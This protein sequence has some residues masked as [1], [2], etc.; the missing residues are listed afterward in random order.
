[1]SY[2]NKDTILNNINRK[3]F[4]VFKYLVLIFAFLFV[5]IT[6]KQESVKAVD[7]ECDI[8]D[9]GANG[10]CSASYDSKKISVNV[11][12]V[13]NKGF[14]S[15]DIGYTAIKICAYSSI[16]DCEI[17]GGFSSSIKI[18]GYSFE[19]DRKTKTLTGEQ[20]SDEKICIPNLSGGGGGVGVLS[21]I[22]TTTPESCNGTVSSVE[23]AEISFS[24]GTIFSDSEY[25]GSQAQAHGFS[26][27]V[28]EWTKEGGSKKAYF[29]VD[30]PAY[31]F[32]VLTLDDITISGNSSTYAK[33]HCPEITVG[34]HYTSLKYAWSSSS[35]TPEDAKFKD[36]GNSSCYVPTS[37]GTYYFHVKAS[38]GYETIIKRKWFGFDNTAPKLHPTDGGYLGVTTPSY[39]D[40]YSAV[41]GYF[42]FQ[43]L[44]SFLSE[45]SF[46]F[47]PA[48]YSY[49][50]YVGSEGSKNCY[51]SYSSDTGIY[52]THKT[53]FKN[54]TSF[55]FE[56]AYQLYFYVKD[57]A[58]NFEIKSIG[59]TLY[60]DNTAP[61][62]GF[63]DEDRDWY[64]IDD[65]IV[66]K[67]MYV[68]DN[69]SGVRSNTIYYSLEKS[70]LTSIDPQG[71]KTLTVNSA[72]GL[73]SAIDLSDFEG[74]YL[75]YYV[76]DN[77]GNVNDGCSTN[78]L[79]IDNVAPVVEVSHSTGVAN[80]H[81]A[82]INV[83][84]GNFDKA[85]SKFC[86]VGS[87]DNC[88]KWIYFSDTRVNVNDTGDLFGIETTAFTDYDRKLN[89]QYQLKLCISDLAGNHVMVD[90]D[91]VEC[92]IVADLNFD[93][94]AITLDSS[95]INV[96]PS[97]G[98]WT[99]IFSNADKDLSNN[100]VYM[101][102]FGLLASIQ[103]GTD[104]T[105]LSGMNGKAA[106]STFKI[107]VGGVDVT[108][109]KRFDVS[110][111]VFAERLY[112]FLDWY[113]EP[114]ADYDGKNVVLTIY[115]SFIK[116]MA[117]NG[118]NS[119]YTIISGYSIDLNSEN[120]EI[121]SSGSEYLYSS[122]STVNLEFNFDDVKIINYEFVDPEIDFCVGEDYKYCEYVG[123][124]I[125][126][127]TLDENEMFITG[128]SGALSIDVSATNFGNLYID[129]ITNVSS[130]LD[131][132]GNQV[133]FASLLG[134]FVEDVYVNKEEIVITKVTTSTY[135]DDLLELEKQNVSFTGNGTYPTVYSNGK[136]NM[137]IEIEF[138][139]FVPDSSV[140]SFGALL[141]NSGIEFEYS[142]HKIDFIT[143]FNVTY[144]EIVTVTSPSL[145]N[146]NKGVYKVVYSLKFKGTNSRILDGENM[147]LLLSGG[148][149]E[150]NS[151]I[152][153]SNEFVFAKLN[154]KGNDSQNLLQESGTIYAFN[155]SLTL[156]MFEGFNYTEYVTAYYI[157]GSSVKSSDNYCD[158]ISTSGCNFDQSVGNNTVLTFDNFK[159]NTI[160]IKSNI[161]DIYGNNFIDGGANL[162]V[163]KDPVYIIVGLQAGVSVGHYLETVSEDTSFE[164]N[165]FV[166]SSTLATLKEENE[167]LKLDVSAGQMD[168]VCLKEITVEYGFFNGSNAKNVEP[169]SNSGSCHIINMSTVKYSDDKTTYEFKLE[170]NIAVPDKFKSIKINL[171]AYDS[172]KVN[173]VR[174]SDKN[175]YSNGLYNKTIELKYNLVD[176]N[177]T[178]P[179]KDIFNYRKSVTYAS[180]FTVGGYS[181][182]ITKTSTSD[183]SGDNVV[184]V[185]T[186]YV[187]LTDI[188]FIL[189]SKIGNLSL[190]GMITKVVTI[191]GER[192][193]S[194]SINLI[195]T[196]SVY[197]PISGEGYTVA[198]Y[199]CSKKVGS[200]YE[201]EATIDKPISA[202]YTGTVK[203]KEYKEGKENADE[204]S[205]SA[206][207]VNSQSVAKIGN[208]K[209]T[210]KVG[211]KSAP[212]ITEVTGP[213]N[214]SNDVC[215]TSGGVISAILTGSSFCYRVDVTDTWGVEQYVTVDASVFSSS[216]L[217]TIKYTTNK[218]HSDGVTLV[219]TYTSNASDKEVTS[220]SLQIV[221]MI[222]TSE[223]GVIK[224][225]FGNKAIA[226][227][228]YDSLVT[229][230]PTVL[231]YD[232][233]EVA[234]P[235]RTVNTN[236]YYKQLSFDVSFNRIVKE[237][238]GSV[239]NSSGEVITD[240]SCSLNNTEGK[241][242]CV[243]KGNH[244]SENY[245]FVSDSITDEY[246]FSVENIEVL[247]ISRNENRIVDNTAP[248]LNYI[249][250]GNK[251]YNKDSEFEIS[252]SSSTDL[253]LNESGTLSTDVID[254]YVD[255]KNKC[256]VLSVTVSKEALASS[257]KIIVKNCQGTG[258]LKYN[259]DANKLE[260]YA[261]NVNIVING[262]TTISIDNGAFGFSSSSSI[263]SDVSYI[264]TTGTNVS[265][266]ITITMNKSVSECK[267]DLIS[268]K[269]N[270]SA[271]LGSCSFDGDKIT[272]SVIATDGSNNGD[273]KLDIKQ[274][275]IKDISGNEMD[276]T[277][278]DTTVNVL[279]GDYV[280]DLSVSVT[281][282]VDNLSDDGYYYC[283][284]DS[285]VTITGTPNREIS[286]TEGA[287][288]SITLGVLGTK[289]SSLDDDEFEFVYTVNNENGNISYNS[290]DLSAFKDNAGNS[291]KVGT[292]DEELGKI[293]IVTGGLNKTQTIDVK[294]GQ[295]HNKEK[296]V[297][298]V[299]S[300]T[301]NTYKLKENISEE[302]L[303]C[304]EA[305]TEC[306]YNKIGEATVKVTVK[307]KAGNTGEILVT[308]SIKSEKIDIDIGNVSV[309][310]GSTNISVE[311]VEITIPSNLEAIGVSEDKVK[312]ALSSML[313]VDTS[314][315]IYVNGETVVID[316][317]DIPIK[318]IKGK[319]I[320]TKKVID[321]SALT[322]TVS[323]EYDGGVN[324]K[325]EKVE[326]SGSYFEYVNVTGGYYYSESVGE[327]KEYRLNLSVTNN[328]Y[329]LSSSVYDGNNGIITQ[330]EL[331]LESIITNISK[332][333]D[334][335]TNVLQTKLEDYTTKYGDKLTISWVSGK[336]ANGVC[337]SSAVCEEYVNLLG[338]S[339]SGTGAGNYSYSSTV[340]VTGKL[341]RD[342]TPLNVEYNKDKNIYIQSSAIGEDKKADVEI[343]IETI[344]GVKV[345][346]VS[347]VTYEWCYFTVKKQGDSR[348]DCDSN[349]SS[350]STIIVTTEADGVWYV[351]SRVSNPSGMQATESFVIRRNDNFVIEKIIPLNSS[352]EEATEAQTYNVGETINVTM[353]FSSIV[354]TSVSLSLGM[355]SDE[356]NS[357]TFACGDF[358]VEEGKT[359]VLCSYTVENNIGVKAI[360]L[361]PSSLIGALY[362]FKDVYGNVLVIGGSLPEISQEIS[363]DTRS[364]SL[365]DV[366]YSVDGKNSYNN[367]YYIKDEEVKLSVSLEFNKVVKT[368]IEKVTISGKTLMC[369]KDSNDGTIIVCSGY[370]TYT[371][372]GV[373][374]I[375]SFGEVGDVSSQTVSFDG[376]N[377][378]LL[379]SNYIS[380]ILP[381]KLENEV[382]VDV[383][384]LEV[385]FTPEKDIV[386]NK[387]DVVVSFNKHFINRVICDDD[388]NNDIGSCSEL[389]TISGGKT[390]TIAYASNKQILTIEY[391]A[392][393]KETLTF[394]LKNGAIQDYVGNSASGSF[395]VIFNNE[396]LD[397]DEENIDIS[398]SGINCIE[399]S[400]VTICGKDSE[401]E[402]VVPFTRKIVTVNNATISYIIGSEYSDSIGYSSID[403][404]GNV[405]FVVPI[406]AGNGYFGLT[407]ITYNVEDEL[408]VVEI[409]TEE[410]LSNE[411]SFEIDTIG[412][413]MEGREI[414]P[415]VTT[416]S[417]NSVL[418]FT[419]SVDNDT[420]Y[421]V[422]VNIVVL[423]SDNTVYTGA[424]VINVAI[425]DNELRIL[426][427]VDNTAKTGDK[428]KVRIHNSNLLDKV[429][430]EI[431]DSQYYYSSL[432]EVNN[433]VPTVSATLSGTNKYY[434]S[435]EIT[436]NVI[437]SG[438]SIVSG[439]NI[440]VINV[441]NNDRVCKT[442]ES[443]DESV[444]FNVS[445]DGLSDGSYK[446]YAESGFVESSSKIESV[447]YL[448]TSVL[449]YVGSKNADVS[450]GN[451]SGFNVVYSAESA[452]SYAYFDA[453]SHKVSFDL[454]A[455]NGDLIS[456]VCSK[457]KLHDGTS[458]VSSGE[459]YDC[460]NNGNRVTITNS[461]L[462]G[463]YYIVI[464]SEIV[465]N[466]YYL[467]SSSKTTENSYKIIAYTRPF[468]NVT[469]EQND[470]NEDVLGSD[471][472]YYVKDDS[473]LKFDIE[474]NRYIRSVNGKILSAKSFSYVYTVNINQLKEGT[475]TV[476]IEVSDQLGNEYTKTIYV[477]LDN[478][479]PEINEDDS[480]QYVYGVTSSN[481]TRTL[482]YI[483]S[484]DNLAVN[485][486]DSQTC[487]NA[488]CSYSDGI[489]TVEFT[490]KDSDLIIKLP[491]GLL[492]DGLNN[493]SQA[494][495]INI[496]VQDAVFVIE[497]VDYKYGD[498][499]YVKDNNVNFVL[500]SLKG[501]IVS[502]E[503]NTSGFTATKDGDAIK[504]NGT[505]NE[506]GKVTFV[507]GA[508]KVRLANNSNI[509]ESDETSFDYV[510]D[511]IDPSVDQIE[512]S[513][514]YAN[515][516]LITLVFRFTEEIRMTPKLSI[517]FGG[518]NIGN[519]E[520]NDGELSAD[521]KS[522]TYK[523][524]A[525]SLDGNV[526]V[527]L[528]EFIDLAGNVVNAE[529]DYTVTEVIIDNKNPK[530]SV[531]TDSIGFVK[532]G[533]IITVTVRAK[534][535]VKF[536]VNDIITLTNLSVYLSDLKYSLD[537][538]SYSGELV[539]DGFNDK[540][541]IQGKVKDSLDSFVITIKEGFVEDK[542]GNSNDLD[543]N[544]EQVNVLRIK[545][546]TVSTRGC[547]DN[548]CKENSL[549]SVEVE[550][551]HEVNVAIADGETYNVTTNNE[552]TLTLATSA[553]ESK[554]HKFSY[555]VTSGV[556]GEISS[557]TF[558]TGKVRDKDIVFNGKIVIDTE[559]VGEPTISSDRTIYG[560]N[561][562]I[563]FDVSF[564]YEEGLKLISGFGDNISVSIAGNKVLFTKDNSLTCDT[565][566]C[567]FSVY[568]NSGNVSGDVVINIGDVVTDRGLNTNVGKSYTVRVETER[569]K[570]NRVTVDGCKEAINGYVYC[571]KEDTI[572]ISVTFDNPLS[573]DKPTLQ[574]SFD[575]AASGNVT[576]SLDGDTI[577]Y[578]YIIS[579]YDSGL[580]SDVKLS[581]GNLIDNLGNKAKLELVAFTKNLVVDNK[582]YVVTLTPRENKVNGSVI[583]DYVCNKEYTTCEL[584][585]SD[586]RVSDG[587]VNVDVTDKT[588]TVSELDASGALTVSLNEGHTVKDY[589]GNVA[590]LKVNGKV[591]VDATKLSVVDVAVKGSGN[592]STSKCAVGG[593]ISV[594]LMFNKDIESYPSDL[595]MSATVGGVS[596]TFNLDKI[597]SKDDI[598][599]FT[600]EVL[601]GDEGSLALVS[602]SSIDIKDIL[603]NVLEDASLSGLN[604]KFNFSVDAEG[605]EEPT[606]NV[607]AIC[608]NS[609]CT[610]G[611]KVVFTFN[612]NE[613]ISAYALTINT[614]FG[615][616]VIDGVNLVVAK[617]RITV[618]IEINHSGDGALSVTSISGN[619][620]DEVNNSSSYDITVPSLSVS[621]D[622]TK[623]VVS[624]LELSKNSYGVS[625]TSEDI[626]LSVSESVTFDTNKLCLRNLTINKL[627][628]SS[629]KL[630]F[631]DSKIT[632]NFTKLSGTFEI[633]LQSGFVKDD[634]G[635]VNEEVVSERFSVSNDK[636][637]III[638]DITGD[639]GNVVVNNVN[640]YYMDSDSS[641][642]FNIKTDNNASYSGDVACNYIKFYKYNNDEQISSGFSCVSDD[643]RTVKITLSSGLE[644]GKYYFEIDGAIISNE[645]G[646][647][648]NSYSSKDIHTIVVSPSSL[649]EESRTLSVSE[650]NRVIVVEE[651]T[652]K[653][654]IKGSNSLDITFTFNSDIKQYS[655]NND[656][657][658]NLG[659]D[660]KSIS[661]RGL[662][663]GS[664][665][666]FVFTDYL[667]NEV[668]VKVEVYKDN[669]A[670][671]VNVSHNYVNN[672]INSNV[673]DL[674]FSCVDTGDNGIE[675]TSS[676]FNCSD[677]TIKVYRE[678]Q[679]VGVSLDATKSVITINE[680]IVD[681]YVYKVEY[682]VSDALNNE[683]RKNIEFTVDKSEPVIS[684]SFNNNVS[685]S[686]N[687]VATVS[688]S[689]SGSGLASKEISY[690]WSNGDNEYTGTVTLNSFNKATIS[691]SSII[692]DGN[693]TLIIA[694]IS[695]N[696]G[697]AC[698]NY[699]SS[700]VEVD[701]TVASVDLNNSGWESNDC[702]EDDGKTYCGKS[703]KI[704]LTIKFDDVITEIY[705]FDSPYFD[706][707]NE[708]INGNTVTMTLTVKNNSISIA[709]TSAHFMLRVID[710]A[711]NINGEEDI[712][713]IVPCNI[714]TSDD[715]SEL[716]VTLDNDYNK[717]PTKV[718]KIE[719]VDTGFAPYTVTYKLNNISYSLE[720]LKN[721]DITST[722]IL[723]VTVTDM[724]GN[725]GV[726]EY[727]IVVDNTPV[728][729]S[730]DIK[731][732]SNVLSDYSFNDKVSVVI[733]T[734]DVDAKYYCVSV[735][736]CDPTS[737]W[738]SYSDSTVTLSE[739]HNT[740]YVYMKDIAGNVS[741]VSKTVS[742]INISA[743][744]NNST[745]NNTVSVTINGLA[746]NAIVKW[747]IVESD[748]SVN[749]ED[750]G[751]T[752]TYVTNDSQSLTLSRKL[753]DV[754]GE[755][756]FIARV[757]V[758]GNSNYI[759]E[760]EV[761]NIL[762]DGKIELD[763][764]AEYND[765]WTNG[766]IAVNLIV[767]NDISGINSV[768]VLKE[769][770]GIYEAMS[771]N[772]CDVSDLGENHKVTCSIS[773]NGKYKIRV[774]DNAGNSIET[775]N[776]LIK[777]TKI[778]REGYTPKLSLPQNVSGV[779]YSKSYYVTMGLEGEGAPINKI[780]YMLLDKE[781]II[782]EFN[783]A[784]YNEK[785]ALSK[786]AGTVENYVGPVSKTVNDVT[787]KYNLYL[788]VK[789]AAGNESFV[790]KELWLD[791]TAPSV[792]F[793]EFSGEYARYNSLEG[794]VSVSEAHV[795]LSLA[796]IKYVDENDQEFS[797]LSLLEGAYKIK[798]SVSD[799]LGNSQVVVSDNYL[800]VDNVGATIER[801]NRDLVYAFPEF[802]VVDKVS[803]ISSVMYCVG[804]S[805][806]EP[807][808]AVDEQELSDSKFKIA[809]TNTGSYTIRIKVL[810]GL[811]NETIYED[812]YSHDAS[813]PIVNYNVKFGN[814][815]VNESDMSLVVDEN[816]ATVVNFNKFTNKPVNVNVEG[817]SDSNSGVSCW[818]M[819][820]TS[821]YVNNINSSC[822]LVD[823]EGT[824]YDIYTQLFTD[825][826]VSKKGSTISINGNFMKIQNIN[827]VYITVFA[828]D[829]A[830]NTS[831][832]VFNVNNL[833]E[834][835]IDYSLSQNTS[836]MSN[837][838]VNVVLSGFNNV[839]IDN[840]SSITYKLGEY[841]SAYDLEFSSYVYETIF[842][843]VSEVSVTKGG[844]T[845][846]VVPVSE[847]GLYVFKV[848]DKWGNAS[849]R[850]IYVKNVDDVKPTDPILEIT[851]F[852]GN[853]YYENSGNYTKIEG[854]IVMGGQTIIYN[855]E[856]K[857]IVKAFA[858]VGPA[859]V[860][861]IECNSGNKCNARELRVETDNE[862]VITGYNGSWTYYLED[863]AGNR[864]VSN[865]SVSYV[866]YDGVD[867]SLDD[868]SITITNTSNINDYT[869]KYNSVTI[870][871]VVSDTSN[872]FDAIKHYLVDAS[873][874]ELCAVEWSNLKSGSYVP[875]SVVE[876]LNSLDGDYRVG[877][878]YRDILGNESDLVVETEVLPLDNVKPVNYGD[879]PSNNI[880]GRISFKLVSGEERYALSYKVNDTSD[881][882]V[883]KIYDK[884]NNLY[885]SISDYEGVCGD[886]GESLV[887]SEKFA[888]STELID[889]AGNISGRI[890]YNLDYVVGRD[891]SVVGGVNYD[892]NTKTLTI[893]IVASKVVG[894]V[895]SV[896]VMADGSEV[897]DL[898]NNSSANTYTLRLNK[899]SY[900]GLFVDG[901]L[902]IDELTFEVHDSYTEISTLVGRVSINNI[903][904]DTND[905]DLTMGNEDVIITTLN[906]DN[907]YAFTSNKVLT[908]ARY[909]LEKRTTLEGVNISNFD[910]LYN[911]CKSISDCAYGVVTEDN[912]LYKAIIGSKE[913]SSYEY[914]LT[915]FGKDE[916]GHSAVATK[917]IFI[918]NSKPV[919]TYSSSPL[920]V[921]EEVAVF[922]GAVTVT[923]S[924]KATSS[925]YNSKIRDLVVYK[926]GEKV[927]EYLGINTEQRSVVVGSGINADG[928]Y[929][930]KAID[931]VGN[932]VEQTIL[933]DVANGGINLYVDGESVGRQYVF[934]RTS[935][936]KLSIVL[937]EDM[938][939]IKFD[940]YNSNE[941]RLITVILSRNG[942]SLIE[943][944]YGSSYVQETTKRHDF[945]LI[946]NSELSVKEILSFADYRVKELPENVDMLRVTSHNR[947]AS[948]GTKNEVSND[949]VIDFVKP[950]IKFRNNVKDTSGNWIVDE[951][952][953]GFN[954]ITTGNEDVIADKFRELVKLFINTVDG[955]SYDSVKDNLTIT[956][957][958]NVSFVAGELD[959][960]KYNMLDKVGTY[961][962]MFEYKDQAGNEAVPV[963]LTIEVVDIIDPVVALNNK[964]IS[965]SIHLTIT[966]E[967]GITYVDEGVISTDNYGFMI[968]NGELEKSST[969][970]TLSYKINGEE[971]E[972]ENDMLML[973]G[974]VYGHK[975]DNVYTFIREGYY[976]FEYKVKDLCG[977]ESSINVNVNVSDKMGPVINDTNNIL[978]HKDPKGRYFEI[979]GKRYDII[980]QEN[981]VYGL[982]YD[983]KTI[984]VKDNKFI[985]GNNEYTIYDNYVK[986]SAININSSNI[987]F[988]TECIF[989]VISAVD[990]Q[991]NENTKIS[992]KGVEYSKD[993]K[994]WGSASYEMVEDKDDK[995]FTLKSI[996]FNNVGYYKIIFVTYDKS[997]N[998]VTFEY[999][1000]KVFD[1001]DKPTFVIENNEYVD[1002]Q[1003]H[1004]VIVN[1005]TEEFVEG[1006]KGL[1007]GSTDKDKLR[1008]WIYNW[1009]S[1010]K[1011]NIIV[1012]H[1013]YSGDANIGY[1014]ISAIEELTRNINNKEFAKYSVDISCTDSSN[1015]VATVTIVFYIIDNL[1016]PTNASITF[1017]YE[1018]SMNNVVDTKDVT[1019]IITNASGLYFRLDNSVDLTNEVRYEYI[1020]IING[1021]ESSDNWVEYDGSVIKAF[1022]STEGSSNEIYVKYRTID[1023]V[1024]NIS[1025][1026]LSSIVFKFDNSMPLYELE[1027]VV[1028][1029]DDEVITREIENLTIYKDIGNIRIVFK[1030][1031][1032]GVVA[1033]EKYVN[1034]N[1035]VLQQDFTNGQYME[1036]SGFGHYKYIIRDGAN[1037]KVV[1038]EYII[1039]SDSNSYKEIDRN[1040]LAN[1041]NNVN[1042][1043][1044][1045]EFDEVILQKMYVD[1046]NKFYFED[1047]SKIGNDDRVYLMGVVPDKTGAIFSI[1048]TGSI[1049]GEI[1050]KQYD[1051]Y[1052]NLNISTNLT[1053]INP[1054]YKLDDYF[1055][1056]FN[1057]DKYILIGIDRGASSDINVNPEDSQGNENGENK[1058][1059]ESSDMT[1060]LLYVLG[1061]VGVIG[1062][1063]FLIM[1064]L[1065]KR[1066]R[1067]A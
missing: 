818:L 390:A 619:F 112:V 325:L 423:N 106:T 591:V 481:I 29:S 774:S 627:E 162:S 916:Y 361:Q 475:N 392:D 290:I 961:E 974:I 745:Y 333:V 520:I 130:I 843:S 452:I 1006:I 881:I 294:L 1024:G 50:E 603:D 201:C 476:E 778:D 282:C 249:N 405:V 736:V 781:M 188:K 590:T 215:D 305:K 880:V 932:V 51:T 618:E 722:S 250:N 251:S 122:G 810:D 208:Y 949:L 541:Y 543:S 78:Y 662:V 621:V 1044:T 716:K 471:T 30:I 645:H 480:N 671:I 887:V 486:N 117:G 598:L 177:T 444:S 1043:T 1059:G 25:E 601:N 852:S 842:E 709:D 943:T 371:N 857:I 483:V 703:D 537:N 75:C 757:S 640:Y 488:T 104:E 131:L 217:K 48:G 363:I 972:L 994:V 753:S 676:G 457:I 127:P 819:V 817:V 447:E 677:R 892:V 362:N 903:Y 376:A 944:L 735:S 56:G 82:D 148:L 262:E 414:E 635:L 870:S 411:S 626:T 105:A 912:G 1033:V 154:V 658:S 428:F 765:V 562:N 573:G 352:Y 147:N 599:V 579:S 128:L 146:G 647:A 742:Y 815:V 597:S 205:A 285:V 511:K 328:N 335:T 555:T 309:E 85:K 284:Q 357:Y 1062:G 924:D 238:I 27:V 696:A 646:N 40:Y 804:S 938:R 57:Q 1022:T 425:I 629:D 1031:D 930:I 521:R 964:N 1019:E 11:P 185:F 926:D 132:G 708:V 99:N 1049:R 64:G 840:V 113:G 1053:D 109:E 1007:T 490:T 68:S 620:K 393:G 286:G 505:I 893:K 668:D 758:G 495:N 950:V 701:N 687:L 828:I 446:V 477:I 34:K 470:N 265:A 704:N 747:G 243:V 165:Y 260:D 789:D 931:N 699:T 674:E 497:S 715:Y 429:N 1039:L 311:G 610:N 565:N 103:I 193:F 1:M 518:K 219:F 659:I 524:I 72:S 439:K 1065:R 401:V 730:V 121:K 665:Y 634:A 746:R 998:G 386:N 499:Y 183:G 231:A 923:I 395:S 433:T 341:I 922:D 829:K 574:L 811:G 731:D 820:V 224:D 891:V 383:E 919:I 953:I 542:A 558:N 318:V 993:G 270:I 947:S 438:G 630:T 510:V 1009:A 617:N 959:W 155:D 385:T 593:I 1016:A 140:S 118:L 726:K 252:F 874:N 32:D 166:E 342:L 979:K 204:A 365:L 264:S 830:G 420:K 1050:F 854:N 882:A 399:E 266:T 274:G 462:D 507:V 456:N 41:T 337:D 786:F 158:L 18:K 718:S 557:F 890:S 683:L 711:G 795:D 95:S 407:S 303:K 160:V 24:L 180:T 966:K 226:T 135:F 397:L 214:Y 293:V 1034:N 894:N 858:D 623:P 394:T 384:D 70:K 816:G 968:V 1017:S 299:S 2:E 807:N 455:V 493:R 588:I 763:G 531:F 777:I 81:T 705:K 740:I 28:E 302:Y 1058:K 824:K 472:T 21:F 314:N 9:G 724:V 951:K 406:S 845:E 182:K 585:A 16:T 896:K 592:C 528:G 761:D 534:E 940:M 449:F 179:N 10:E 680:E 714:D 1020:V 500:R 587:V 948:F 971:I 267:N 936:E 111:Y 271:K 107:E 53:D 430:N 1014:V 871:Y 240:S 498:N 137:K 235:V 533:D 582:A 566:T 415:S 997:A 108:N 637:N 79:K 606:V 88:V 336:Y 436:I 660:R 515:G 417:S 978:I 860:S 467:N 277:E 675:A 115:S 169:N 466:D 389:F 1057:G 831:K 149:I 236:K 484:D 12:T 400:G 1011:A 366:T 910:R 551:N 952:I 1027:T 167:P 907:T 578:T 600:Y 259:V 751:Y 84:D 556:N 487:E 278:V 586:L 928:Y 8:V 958:E 523:V 268:L 65:K 812:T 373:L 764:V 1005:Y 340:T 873:G 1067:A 615:K 184:A 304:N 934:N 87:D 152:G 666:S 782:S 186:F 554:V 826:T 624:G 161:Y 194:D 901:I 1002:G 717:N 379:D 200:E 689:E 941:I 71:W 899:T 694:S 176:T 343:F 458:F 517:A 129:S 232:S 173:L 98:G 367:N 925:A 625:D 164:Y 729:F 60:L 792:E 90:G 859:K 657:T 563:R 1064:K 577:T 963:V 797:D 197:K 970:Y 669:S 883:I 794:I 144:G 560:A 965:G 1025:D 721:L 4:N 312:T 644:V 981:I 580:I 281:N 331:K 453:D 1061:V 1060:W 918:D 1052:F 727:E 501:Q 69:G 348:Y 223:N 867:S 652:T 535:D 749:D 1037:N 448:S 548:Y 679:E 681:G 280:V 412:M 156:H 14:L 459:G 353:V 261:G 181:L 540:L 902:D 796:D 443:T 23:D 136:L 821:S 685:R 317:I 526:Y 863:E 806:C 935:L 769:N 233:V 258:I 1055:I 691:G 780:F 20:I 672:Y 196:E 906:K 632:I 426:V 604:A 275:A 1004:E 74:G 595:S 96:Q 814:A 693:Y 875:T 605:V 440:C 655:F 915:V 375:E 153:S 3:V 492:Y 66:K 649:E 171:I 101:G 413:S 206:E 300:D 1045:I 248:T 855:G 241:F 673:I 967:E 301:N 653:Y 957:N 628:C 898:A 89:G 297:S 638:S 143:R 77:V 522:V 479:G 613:K 530:V 784:V 424:N 116:D 391:S 739:G 100:D 398:V 7:V 1040:S 698:G 853:A 976:V 633:V 576:S 421:N 631:S 222:T 622:N 125:F 790:S 927:Q 67:N 1036:D 364:G 58:G 269:D 468:S 1008:S 141:D 942:E 519:R 654:F 234:T 712:I 656:V 502:L 1003:T 327:G 494:R 306:R 1038:V 609:V 547:A 482:K 1056:N 416:I 360:N 723:Q 445:S 45:V 485:F 914:R 553:S 354:N 539:Q 38:N 289:N 850:K 536:N 33:T 321:V 512:A 813:G 465:T 298:D 667:G 279:N 856:L 864:S 349:S 496:K 150:R 1013:N 22:I 776:G 195:N 514:I 256:D 911:E 682:F 921:D 435:G 545:N 913:L 387:V 917:Y 980:S 189:E 743:S 686:E 332:V 170:Y 13:V 570:V 344:N 748:N 145:S 822:D 614:N 989:N 329:E 869:K 283:K 247:V 900:P 791:N 92:Y 983:N 884:D 1021:H 272:I 178:K 895:T 768:V 244:D 73:T 750:Y 46:C 55:Y 114:V 529:S 503:G 338:I 61:D 550:Y 661:F 639:Y 760:I 319:L 257:I 581:G 990:A 766:N 616:L 228:T 832:Y 381:N 787:G 516:D 437:V 865:V 52:S 697:N 451:I 227:A 886:I 738:S 489:L 929:M 296:I 1023:G 872:R 1018:E 368:A 242:I 785:L 663:E 767:K 202:N 793:G 151:E 59:S 848:V 589:A 310:Y 664:I 862:F 996:K 908:D 636:D 838:G 688:V 460:S 833:R 355:K 772:V 783:E 230:V 350:T 1012:K 546:T 307:D 6:S 710:D 441:T 1041:V 315:N 442:M 643:N 422:N 491:S 567:K 292:I 744:N 985:L 801:T 594:S 702:Y 212:V 54:Y 995:L 754:Q 339:L 885:C 123:T 47:A 846:V 345:D 706:M 559:K 124:V 86:L 347:N 642:R 506:S 888:F 313:E 377:S 986:I 955:K 752:K 1028:W 427:K 991:Y 374:Y 690:I 454:N 762:V 213:Y 803:G 839:G 808:K 142:G 825:K 607:E 564:I 255:E 356:N 937:S 323:K 648:S 31:Y 707:S 316:E 800:L 225:S 799:T 36:I 134:T 254:I 608:S 611:D 378:L 602:L 897:V 868:S 39:G 37:D 320:I 187:E 245:Y 102:Q 409:E 779:I 866:Y 1051:Q 295:V 5:G 771:D 508:F 695:D 380:N 713:M 408:G 987:C 1032:S 836:D 960:T 1015:N 939:L 358:F 80:N 63:E 246:G 218:K 210:Y 308:I 207:N 1001:D 404:D 773:E 725:V 734:S 351:Y 834:Q 525:G 91:Y 97:V 273:I 700:N 571:K 174:V 93:N 237:G 403:E 369:A 692:N 159:S 847:N 823:Y 788:Y 431:E 527:K 737:E 62:V 463:M 191:T 802:S 478:K 1063:G 984:E 509:Y 719:V 203:F 168:I 552:L 110:Y 841:D 973:D 1054:E 827:Q 120:L 876:C 945:D 359:Y 1066:V 954:V 889:S 432:V 419:L 469:F 572:T 584:S 720:E 678:G 157:E 684:V 933:V 276:A 220:V 464:E 844:S 1026:E 956:I 291:G 835:D 1047:M 396:S 513:G 211:D 382:F 849:Y 139:M 1035:L 538:N 221:E 969:S 733:N 410:S 461:S 651:N 988:G 504:V 946:M 982:K 388:A 190:N 568:V 879:D 1030:D 334:N 175:V 741:S 324:V 163:S 26:I 172:S 83:I 209:Y 549:I 851:T 94:A 977:N 805:S 878:K 133:N 1046:G 418:Q 759:K 775:G 372:P 1048:Y 575:R 561:T 920:P 43:D 909:M 434:S 641:L 975:A 770:N 612:F 905:V 450:I 326:V 192:E 877:Y 15:L 728:K 532:E 809:V 263:S 138:S 198:S 861:L 798:V 42:Q 904:Y 19:I 126:S 402:V 670:P 119:E 239:K 999:V 17:Q 596:K 76:S 1010:N 322:F 569:P 199:S 1042:E 583:Y 287:N 756:K 1029:V 962:V 473:I 650:A 229:L 992:V 346:V 732:G 474:M 288:A 837:N 253:L 1000:L 330:Y 755:Y 544:S 44:Y 35:S 370:V 49:E 216:L